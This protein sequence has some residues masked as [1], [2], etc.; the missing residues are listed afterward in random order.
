MA[1]LRKQL[2]ANWFFPVALIL[3]LAVWGV[4][5]SASALSQADLFNLESAL[6]ADAFLTLPVLY[7][8][9]FRGRQ[10]KGKLLL[11][12]IAVICSGLWLAGL[13]VPPSGQALLPQVAWLRYLG[14]AVIVMVEVR[15]AVLAVRLV[16]QPNAKAADLESHGV[17]PVIAKLMLLEAR[18]WRWVF[19]A[20]R[21]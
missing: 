1:H 17:P 18:F 6:V 8:L 13:I 5:K 11:G 15:I 3:F 4:V 9:C 16:W 19:S 12:V 7:W 21:K 2:A 14:L 20:F 10:S